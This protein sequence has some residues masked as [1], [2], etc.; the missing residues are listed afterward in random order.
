MHFKA[1]TLGVFATA[2][3]TAGVNAA[4]VRPSVRKEWRRMSTKEKTNWISAVKCLSHLPH[5]PNMTPTVN[6]SLSGIPPLNTSGSYYDDFVYMHMDLNIELCAKI[7]F[8]GLFLPWHRWYVAVYEAAL[9]DKCGYIG[10]SPY[11]NWTIDA[12]NFLKSDFWKDNDTTSG[13]GG[14]GDPNN[15]YQVPDGAFSDFHLSYPSTHTLRRNFTLQPYLDDPVEFFKNPAKFANTSFTQK[16]ISNL[17]NGYTGDYKGFQAYFEFFEGAHSS[18]HEIMGGDLAGQCPANAPSNCTAG[19]TWS[20]NEPLFW[21]HHAMVDKVWYDWQHRDSANFWSFSGGSVQAFEN[22]TYYTEYPNG[23]APFLSETVCAAQFHYAS[24]WIVPTVNDIR[25]VQ[26]DGR[27]P[28]LRLRVRTGELPPAGLNDFVPTMYHTLFMRN[29]FQSR[30][31]RW[32]Y[33]KPATFTSFCPILSD[34]KVG[35]EMPPDTAVFARDQLI[36]FLQQPFVTSLVSS[37]PNSVLSPKGFPVPEAW[38]SWWEWAASRPLDS[39]PKWVSLLRSYSQQYGEGPESLTKTDPVASSIPSEILDFIKDAKL[40]QLDRSP[41]DWSNLSTCLSSGLS[42]SEASHASDVALPLLAGMSPKK[43]HEVSRMA[44]YIA[45]LTSS[46]SGLKHVKYI[47]D[48]GAGQGYLSRAL[49]DLG[50]HVLALDGSAVQTT[51][52]ERRREQG[53][54]KGNKGRRKNRADN[55]SAVDEKGGLGVPDNG[56]Q[57]QA[58]S[59]THKTIHITADNLQKAVSAWLSESRNDLNEVC[60]EPVPV[61]VVALHSCGTLTPDIFP[62][63]PLSD[64]FQKAPPLSP[65]HHQLAAQT[66]AHW[67]HSPASRASTQLSL[68]K[69]VYRAILEA[70]L[71]HGGDSPC[72]SNHS[73]TIPREEEKGRGSKKRIGRLPDNAY[74]S[75]PHFISQASQKLDFNIDASSVVLPGGTPTAKDDSKPVNMNASTWFQCMESRLEVLHVLRCLIGPCVETLIL[76]DRLCWLREKLGKDAVGVEGKWDVQLVGLFNQAA[77]S[78]RNFALVIIPLE[79]DNN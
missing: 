33:L 53:Q 25:C 21:M 27:N 37:H 26:Y 60:C 70:C 10:S 34:R 45:H 1:I 56:T 50:F 59:L 46:S 7:H 54:A 23:A 78:A 57:L 2:F 18:V 20:A 22:D 55:V 77:G 65:S 52:A 76:M 39:E 8:T 24:R 75:F 28:L 58:G 47:V 69:I 42:T 9:K 63:F 19:P 16:E 66:P 48:I 61:L 72:A 74:A 71:P 67:L 4:C 31:L 73:E 64:A 68:R 14:W 29:G 44:S 30:I 6:V 17:I 11:W 32:S 51:G 3:F 79:N 43:A 62:D 38:S 49:A 41:V 13:L 15:D 40:L 35:K 12:P 36:E 5:D